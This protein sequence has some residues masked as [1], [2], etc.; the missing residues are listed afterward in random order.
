M[1][2]SFRQRKAFFSLPILLY[3]AKPIFVPNIASNEK[4][5]ALSG[6]F[7]LYFCIKYRF[8]LIKIISGA[9]DNN[10]RNAK[11]RIWESP[12]RASK[13]LKFTKKP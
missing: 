12:V 11:K 7:V 4:T 10:E 3:F 8:L 5:L 6:F 2:H 1:T 13:M 9:Y